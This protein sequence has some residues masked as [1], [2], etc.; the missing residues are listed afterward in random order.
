MGQPVKTELQIPQT[1]KQN[2]KENQM[3]MQ[4]EKLQKL[5]DLKVIRS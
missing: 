3:Y 1:V 2:E 4:I 5:A